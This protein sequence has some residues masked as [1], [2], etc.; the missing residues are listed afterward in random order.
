MDFSLL[1]QLSN[2]NCHIISFIIP[3]C[4]SESFL[5]YGLY[6]NNKAVNY[7]NCYWN[8]IRCW[9]GK[10]F[11][12]LQFFSGGSADCLL[13]RMNH[14]DRLTTWRA[15]VWRVQKSSVQKFFQF[16]NFFSYILVITQI[17]KFYTGCFLGLFQASNW[18]TTF[19][20][21]Q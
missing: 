9:I 8:F 21:F 4:P 15:Q 2:Q 10:Q 6:K 7:G 12:K 1:T 11:F 17:R 18:W 16:F 20:N 13:W 3:K 5:R 19:H 14:V